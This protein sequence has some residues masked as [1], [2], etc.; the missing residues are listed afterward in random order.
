MQA[1]SGHR[2]PESWLA[3]PV[4]WR[5]RLNLHVED[6]FRSY[7]LPS[8]SR[9][10]RRRC[11]HASSSTRLCG[12]PAGW[13]PHGAGAQKADVLKIVLC[14]PGERRRGYGDGV[15]AQLV[16]EPLLARWVR[17]ALTI[18]CPFRLVPFFPLAAASSCVPCPRAW[19]SSTIRCALRCE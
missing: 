13:R 19:A 3:L 10:S 9:C 7:S 5:N 8:R 18:R 14:R 12:A 15:C 11:T 4:R 17:T 16:Y 6:E 1:R 2:H